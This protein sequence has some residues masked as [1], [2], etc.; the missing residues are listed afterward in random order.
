[1][2][3][4]GRFMAIEGID[5]CGKSTLAQGI[6]RELTKIGSHVVLTKEP[7]GSQLGKYLRDILNT[8]Q[9]QALPVCDQSEYLLFAADRAQHFKQVIEPALR[10]GST[11]ISDRWADS[12]VAYQGYG[13][14]LDI[15][16]IKSI[17]SWVTNAMTPD[18][19]FYI[20]IEPQV[21]LSRVKGRNFDLTAFEKEKLDFWTKVCA[22]Y[23][24]TLAG[25]AEVRILDGLLD[26]EK[27]LDA[28]LNAME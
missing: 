3:S 23:D 11:V 21:A 2:L 14:G 27:L 18:L 1:M 5:G 25:R 19:I 7:G 9:N 4:T 13:R 8:L 16:M 22:G 17:N 12:S 24:Q 26:P 15:K 28:A 6:A 20:R 10:S